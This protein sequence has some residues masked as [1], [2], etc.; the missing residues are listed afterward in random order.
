MMI[1]CIK[2]DDFIEAERSGKC[3]AVLTVEGGAVLAG[4]LVSIPYLADCGVR[5]LT[6]TWNGTCEFGDGA[7]VEN[8]K[9]GMIFNTAGD[10]RF[11][12]GSWTGTP[13]IT[14]K[15]TTNNV[16]INT[17]T[18][19]TINKLQ[20]NGSAKIGGAITTKT[21]VITTNTTLNATHNIV[22]VSNGSAVTLPTA[23]GIT[24]RQYNVIRSGASNVT[25]N[26]TSSQTI[27]GDNNLILTSQWDSVVVVSDGSNW[28]RC[29]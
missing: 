27:S 1:Q 8:P 9:G 11:V 13:V 25:I 2:Q 12:P 3:G 15:N 21:Q 29:S 19:D 17:A 24:G 5:M 16:L 28:V 18:D 22:I 20:V 23:V 26:T 4:D 6:L 10:I 7:M 14:A